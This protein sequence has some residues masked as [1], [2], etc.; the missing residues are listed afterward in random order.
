MK[1]VLIISGS[2]R[3]KGNSQRLCEEFKKG[4]EDKGNSVELIRLAEKKIGFC[5]ACD[6]C[7]KNNG[8]CV[9]KDD[10]AEVLESFLKSRCS[11]ISNTCIF[12]RYLRSNENIY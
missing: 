3:K 10:M 2:P 1:N 4:A 6:V 5:K 7:M 12:L 11:G 8:T 9:Q